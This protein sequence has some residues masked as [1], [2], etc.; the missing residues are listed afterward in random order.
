M[1]HGFYIPKLIKNY[2]EECI[3]IP[4]I[5]VQDEGQLK[6][7]LGCKQHGSLRQLRFL[8]SPTKDRLRLCCHPTDGGKQLNVEGPAVKPAFVALSFAGP[9]GNHKPPTICTQTSNELV[10]TVHPDLKA[11]NRRVEAKHRR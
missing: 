11:F 4:C 7:V 8:V 10:R 1:A 6:V 3:P 2:D 5:A 9:K